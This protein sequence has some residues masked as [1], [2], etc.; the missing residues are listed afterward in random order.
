MTTKRRISKTVN[1]TGLKNKSI[2]LKSDGLGKYTFP[3]AKDVPT[4]YYASTIISADYCSTRS[5]DRAIEVFYEIE[6]IQ[7]YINRVKGITV[8]NVCDVYY[9]IKQ[10]YV[11]NSEHFKRFVDAMAWVLDKP[12]GI[13]FST[14]SVINVEEY[15]RL[16]Y[17]EG[18]TIGSIVDRAPLRSLLE[19]LVPQNNTAEDNDP[20]SDDNA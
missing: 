5:C 17:P 7:Q 12:V 14:E 13:A 4:G 6:P 8:K 3:V 19:F 15:I 9:H 10:K 1:H 18:S 16:E 2:M 11:L 20:N